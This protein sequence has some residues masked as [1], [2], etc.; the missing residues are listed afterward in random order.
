M[1]KPPQIRLLKQGWE[2]DVVYLCQFPLVP[3]V[4]TISPFSLKL[5]TW[6]RVA[7]VK[8][9]NIFTRRFHART[10]LIPY[11]ELNG[12]QFT[13]SS[14]IIQMLEKRFTNI[15]QE[16]SLEQRSV[17]HL[18]T[19]MV[20]HFTAQTGFYYRYG[21]HMREFVTRLQLEE[22]YASG[23]M[24]R[25]WTLVQPL[26][27]RLR[28]FMSG[29]SRQEQSVVW[30]QASQDLQALSTLLGDKQYFHG[31]SPTTI[32]CMIFGHLAQF[33]YID[34]GFPQKVLNE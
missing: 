32:D 28:S 21:L 24:I 15:D 34:I 11:I 13:D 9:E 16:L 2:R 6:L 18:A 20:E 26:I 12:E 4:R 30:D 29:V 19:V 33:L 14:L 27:T 3:S 7:G 5:E 22:F 10:G 25:V 17:S 8:Y 23:G 31:D 1:K